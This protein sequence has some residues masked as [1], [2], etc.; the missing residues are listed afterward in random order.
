MPISTVLLEYY[1]Y[2]Y[3][4]CVAKNIKAFPSARRQSHLLEM[5]KNEQ[6]KQL[7]EKQFSDTDTDGF[8]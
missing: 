8:K 1:Y 7:E 5:V 2:Y 6:K 4:T 3:F